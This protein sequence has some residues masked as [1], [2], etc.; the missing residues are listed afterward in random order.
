MSDRDRDATAHSGHGHA[1]AKFAEGV[2]T[3]EQPPL[4]GQFES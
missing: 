1:D 3:T 4:S 2:D